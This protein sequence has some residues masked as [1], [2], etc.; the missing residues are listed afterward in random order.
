MRA[1]GDVV[2]IHIQEKPS[3]Y[4]RIESIEAD[5]KPRWYQVKLL[6]LTFP[7]QE[8]TWILRREYMEGALFTMNDIPVQIF[9]LQRQAAPVPGSGRKPGTQGAEVISM[10]LA[11]SRKDPKGAGDETEEH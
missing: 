9:P 4:A 7:P 10:D 5:V 6:F 3:V 11:R 2:A 1:I 8:V